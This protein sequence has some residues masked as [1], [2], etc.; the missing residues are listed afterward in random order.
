MGP[1]GSERE[2][3]FE[4]AN[5]AN[6]VRHVPQVGRPLTARNPGSKSAEAEKDLSSI[7]RFEGEEV[8]A[9]EV[10]R[11]VPVEDEVK[12]DNNLAPIV[13]SKEAPI[14]PVR[15]GGANF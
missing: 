5:H 3:G 4:D 8:V 7:E 14:E 6:N 1:F 9:M 2:G 13:D 11:M 15:P 10:V 12:D